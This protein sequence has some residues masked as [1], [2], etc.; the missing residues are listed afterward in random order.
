MELNVK[1]QL[2]SFVI[3]FGVLAALQS[4][5]GAA[6]NL[7]I[8]DLAGKWCGDV[9]NY[10]FAPDQF[11]VTP[12]KHQDLT[13]GTKLMIESAEPTDDGGLKVGWHSAK[14]DGS[15]T[16]TFKLSSDRRLLLQQQEKDVK[17]RT[18]HRC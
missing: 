4:T 1:R 3:S 17:A 9:T 6:D 11:V 7:K 16:T 5:A 8:D 15:R 13:F 18:F 2:I 14:A 10:T 12:K